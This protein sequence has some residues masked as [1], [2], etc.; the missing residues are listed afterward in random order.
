M[1]F[2]FLLCGAYTTD[3]ILLDFFTRAKNKNYEVSSA[4]LILLLL[5]L[6]VV[7]VEVEVE[8][9]VVMLKWTLDVAVLKP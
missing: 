4:Y 2:Y 6:L 1:H 5:L 3:F 7:V 8:V 9:E